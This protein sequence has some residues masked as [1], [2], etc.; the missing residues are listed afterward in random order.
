M[1]GRLD[2]SGSFVQRAE[3]PLPRVNCRRKGRVRSPASVNL[4]AL[5]PV[6]SAQDVLRC[7]SVGVFV[8]GHRNQD[9]EGASK[10]F[11]PG[12]TRINSRQGAPV[13]HLRPAE[14]SS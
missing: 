10:S 1:R 7:Q 11:K 8:I 13:R 6:Q 12:P 14:L 2:A 9:T 3:P 5:G 4:S